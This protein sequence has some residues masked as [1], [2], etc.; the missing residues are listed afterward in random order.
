MRNEALE[1]EAM[2][3]TEENKKNMEDIKAL[4]QISLAELIPVA[5]PAGAAADEESKGE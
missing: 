1:D 4:N 2:L 5:K 3:F